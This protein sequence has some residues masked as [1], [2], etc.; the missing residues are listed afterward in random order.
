M[1]FQKAYGKEQLREG[2]IEQPRESTEID[3]LENM[4]QELKQQAKN[5]EVIN[6]LRNQ[7]KEEQKRIKELKGNFFTKWRN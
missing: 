4:L 5:I 2:S 3:R 1:T 6:E 7:I